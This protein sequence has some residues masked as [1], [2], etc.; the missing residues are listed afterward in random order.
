MLAQDTRRCDANFG[1]STKFKYKAT[2]C[3]NLHQAT[4]SGFKFTT[5]V[6]A[7]VFLEIKTHRDIF[8]KQNLKKVTVS[9]SEC[10]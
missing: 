8:V 5:S 4:G 6:D 1:L 10:S 3:Y 2:V 7:Y 9:S